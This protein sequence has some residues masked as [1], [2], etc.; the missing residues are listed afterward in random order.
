MRQARAM[1][2]STSFCASALRPLAIRIC[3]AGPPIWA[4]RELVGLDRRDEAGE[5]EV[6]RLRR[7]R[8]E[9]QELH[10]GE[11]GLE[12]E[13]QHHRDLGRASRHEEIVK[14]VARRDRRPFVG[15]IG[16]VRPV[17]LAVLG[18]VFVREVELDL[19]VAVLVHHAEGGHVAHAGRPAEATHARLRA[20]RGVFAERDRA[21]MGFQD[22]APAGIG[23]LV[24]ARALER[25]LHRIG[26]RVLLALDAHVF[27]IGRLVRLVVDVPLGHRHAHRAGHDV[28]K[29]VG[30]GDVFRRPVGGARDVVPFMAFEQG[31]GA[32]SSVGFS[33]RLRGRHVRGERKSGA[34]GRAFPRRSDARAPKRSQFQGVALRLDRGRARRGSD[35]S[36]RAFTV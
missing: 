15:V 35:R 13:G 24:D 17:E 28:R 27:R 8:C 12:G 9:T 10:V 23:V 14:G 31:H 36:E 1:A 4:W 33:Q 34:R 20:H 21:V 2:M 5:G 32:V 16:L 6:A 22:R 29:E 19:G 26:A 11:A 7:V 3:S 30:L 25:G 18:R